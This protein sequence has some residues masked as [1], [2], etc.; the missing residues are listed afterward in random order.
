[1]IRKNLQQGV[2]KRRFD[3]KQQ[4][5]NTLKTARKRQI[6]L[7]DENIEAFKLSTLLPQVKYD[8]ILKVNVEKQPD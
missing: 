5:N 8:L 1:M 3:N 6:K 4:Y 2:E 7:V